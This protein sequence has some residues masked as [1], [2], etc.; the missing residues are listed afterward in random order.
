MGTMEPN[1]SSCLTSDPQPGDCHGPWTELR[2]CLSDVG[3]LSADCMIPVGQLPL[4]GVHKTI[5]QMSQQ[6]LFLMH[7]SK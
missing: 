1:G 2:S 4:A 5:S 7:A 3:I 6:A